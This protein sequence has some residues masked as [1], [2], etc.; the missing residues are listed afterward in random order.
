MLHQSISVV[1]R[2]KGMTLK[3]W[4]IYYSDEQRQ[5]CYN[6]V[7]CYRN[8]TLTDYFEN[9][10]IADLV[11]KTTADYVG[12]ISWRLKEKRQSGLCPMILNIYGDDDLSEEKILS[13]G[14]DVINLR[15]FS[16]GHQMLANAAKYHGGPQHNYAWE[17][18]IEELKKF[19]HI[20]EEVKHPI[21]ENAFV[22]KRDIYVYYVR[23]CLIPVM[24]FMRDN[25][26][27]FADS[28]YAVKKERTDPESVKQYRAVSGRQDWPLAPFLLERLFS[29]YIND[30]NL[31]IVNA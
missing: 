22:A 13:T 18:A 30:L 23:N 19:M 25:P 12:V 6:F 1:T 17:N 16:Y 5:H 4:Q 21:Y 9:T 26:V 7:S 8:Y 20:P 27:F 31:K 15:P 14:A 11:P 2:H 29:I 28:G 10:L 24:D 3:L